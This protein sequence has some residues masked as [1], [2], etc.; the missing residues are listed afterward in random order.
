L[1]GLKADLSTTNAKCENALKNSNNNNLTVKEI[2]V[3]DSSS[4]EED[5][6]K[7]NRENIEEEKVLN[8]LKTN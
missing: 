8:D 2:Q 7:T 3:K 1:L 4:Q 6:T 5:Y